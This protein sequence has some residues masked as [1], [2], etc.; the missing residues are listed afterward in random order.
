MQRAE[1]VIRAGKEQGLHRGA[2]LFVHHRGQTVCD[3]AFGEAQPDVAMRN[4]TPMLWMS[5]GKPLAAVAMLQQIERGRATLDTRV[6]QVLPAFA[7]NGK[8]AITIR[9]L[10][11]HTAGFRGPLN[12][13]T[14][15]P[16]EAIIERVC[17]LK[18][19]PGWTPGEKAGYHVGSSWFILGE[20][21]RL[22]DG[23]RYEQYVREEIFAR[24]GVN[25]STVGLLSIEEYDA[26]TTSIVAPDF[27]GNHPVDA[28]T[29]CRPGANARGPIRDLAQFYI[30]LLN[31]DGRLL[32]SE[33]SRQMVARQREGMFDH[34]FKEI[35]DWGWGVKLDSKRYKTREERPE[36][37]G[38]GLHASDQTFGHSGNQ[39]SCAFADPAHDLV[40]AWCTNGMPGEA[41]HQ[42][43]QNAINTA[44]YEDLKLASG[45]MA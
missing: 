15:G 36:Q 33:M 43:R 14:P 21:V 19:E 22:L 35:T 24:V 11:T 1:R 9:H 30:S 37:Y 6:A 3:Q 20:L 27:P 42:E 2:Q 5:A 45:S 26:R 44:I 17:R 41:A 16:W 34:T 23:R 32:S 39:C 10:L 31:H 38:Y 13:F 29:V 18:Q 28:L 40:V 8:D 25:T 7:R 4:T 12:S